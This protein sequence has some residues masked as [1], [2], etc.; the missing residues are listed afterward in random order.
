MREAR[1]PLSSSL[2]GDNLRQQRAAF[3]SPEVVASPHRMESGWSREVGQRLETRVAGGSRR[4]RL[5][6]P[7]E[8][9]GTM[10]VELVLWS[11]LSLHCLDLA[12]CSQEENS[13]GRTTFGPISVTPSA[14]KQQFGP[15]NQWQEQLDIA[16]DYRAAEPGQTGATSTV[17]SGGAGLRDRPSPH[18]ASAQVWLGQTYP[19]I[20]ESEHPDLK[21]SAELKQAPANNILPA[22]GPRDKGDG[23]K[24]KASV[25]SSS[26][27]VARSGLDNQLNLS[28]QSNLFAGIACDQANTP[29][30]IDIMQPPLEAGSRLPSSRTN[31][32]A[33]ILFGF[34]PIAA[35]KP[36]PPN[37]C[38][39]SNNSTRGSAGALAE[40]GAV[41]GKLARPQAAHH[42]TGER[43][44]QTRSPISVAVPSEP[45][46]FKTTVEQLA[47]EL[48]RR[49]H[50]AYRIQS[51]HQHADAGLVADSAD[52]SQVDPSAPAAWLANHYSEP[53]GSRFT[54]RTHWR[55]PAWADGDQFPAEVGDLSSVGNH[56]GQYA[57]M[58]PTDDDLFLVPGSLGV[59]FEHANHQVST[60]IDNENSRL[61]QS[62]AELGSR[63]SKIKRSPGLSR[64]D[65]EPLDLADNKIRAQTIYFGGFFPW[66]TG[67]A[68]EQQSMEDA[69]A[70]AHYHSQPDQSFQ[71]KPKGV[72]P[73]LVQEQTRE[74][75]GQV[76]EQHK[77]Q[78]ENRSSLAIQG[79]LAD[80]L[81]TS[82]A[83]GG[84]YQLGRF[85]LPAVR[86]ALDHIN[87]NSTLLG[88]YRL[89]IVPRDTQVSRC[90]LLLFGQRQANQK[91][92][93]TKPFHPAVC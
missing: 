59:S 61:L 79:Q 24:S 41:S 51:S 43:V 54:R 93:G 76:A 89:E 38:S 15:T 52:L 69:T 65:A 37:K 42:L 39:S 29:D 12:L 58:A 71:S 68:E 17:G 1:Q 74:H 21:S 70:G 8:R 67:S 78:Y 16:T 56:G 27:R 63:E 33:G 84:R 32:R 90:A 30:D 9:V 64:N 81:V 22:Q 49:R 62:S 86:L 7:M 6:A 47:N 60:K 48:R 77:R 35:S 36:N 87:K 34:Q 26:S 83:A 44:R 19:S 23:H 3:F 11:L 88:S 72:K 46:A 73:N 85:L 82:N 40:I 92:A 25:A 4:S 20:G 14:I 53:I 2:V 55:R 28:N 18:L 75:L 10:F 13:I 91:L 50:N 57:I 5:S 45:Q 66:L 31:Q 80:S